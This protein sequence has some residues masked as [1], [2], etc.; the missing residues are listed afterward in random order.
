MTRRCGF[1]VLLAC[2]LVMI[3][4]GT[5]RAST[6]FSGPLK[7]GDRGT[8]VAYLQQ[9]LARQGL[10]PAQ[11][12]TGY[13]GSITRG[14]VQNLEKKYGLPVDG[15]VAQAEWSILFGTS[16]VAPKNKRLVLGY[17]TTDYPGDQASYQ[18][19]AT[20]AGYIDQIATFDCWVNENGYLQGV[21]S[22]DALKLSRQKNVGMQ[23]LVHNFMNGGFAGDFILRVL[24]NPRSRQ[25]L[26][27]EIVYVVNKYSLAGVN[28]DFEGIP[29]RGRQVYTTFVRELAGRLAGEGRLLTLSVPAKSADNP[30]NSWSG[31][32]DYAALGQLADYLA[33]MTY[34][35][36]WWGGAPGP[37]A[38]LPWVVSVLD[39]ATAVIPAQKVLLGIG[40]YGY[41][42]PEQR[43]GR[44]VKWK[45][46]PALIARTA[47]PQWSEQYSVP[48][49]V[50]WQGGVKHQVWFE[51]KYSLA[52]KLKLL[53]SY[54]LGGIAVW[55]LGY[56]DAQFWQTVAAGLR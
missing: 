51:N 41:D 22:A 24:E 53:S 5:A 40:C 16:A 19:L 52:I 17:Y 45:D 48:H 27:R 15:R 44:A 37:V 35:Q 18:D 42:W 50:Y 13:Y 8:Q 43:V 55:R 34:D 30:Y 9:A 20:Y 10:F 36:H 11:L 56:T 23:L 3:M 39:Y 4:S 54:N 28:I 46:M 33:I 38:S 29:P 49:L 47:Q 26:V 32:Y 12:I 7:P 25:T 31:A 14:A 2:W 6:L 21:P 1:V